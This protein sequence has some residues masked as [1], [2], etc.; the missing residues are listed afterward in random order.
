MKSKRSHVSIVT[1]CYLEL[2]SDKNGERLETILKKYGKK[3]REE[4]LAMIEDDFYKRWGKHSW[5]D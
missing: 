4:A 1:A 3:T 5:E 2:K